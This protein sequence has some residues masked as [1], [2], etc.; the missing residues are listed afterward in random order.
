MADK[1]AKVG[2][3]GCGGISGKYLENSKKFSAF[4]IVAVAD[5]RVEAAKAKAVEYDIPQGCSVEGLLADPEVDIILNLTPHSAHGSVGI[6]ALDAGK[7]IYN[8]K[9]LAVLR[10]DG[11]KMLALAK[12]KGLRVGAAPDTFFGG[13]WQTARKLIDDGA[14]G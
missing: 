14:I 1:A 11:Q 13:A 12:E 10:E 9:P 6:A 4:D 2:V 7:S 5:A 8:E 3:I